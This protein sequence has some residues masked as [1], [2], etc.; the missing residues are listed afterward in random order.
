MAELNLTLR[1]VDRISSVDPA[2]W[3]ACAGSDNPFLLHGFLSA[4][5][6]SGS[7]NTRSGWQPAH[8]LVENPAK[9]L[10][11]AAPLYV[12]SHS[13]GEYVFDWGW[14]EA[15]QNA[16]RNY[17]PKLQ[18]AVPFTPAT[19]RRLLV[20]PDQDPL[21]LT[22]LLGDAMIGIADRNKLSS[23]HITFLTE[24][25]ARTLADH[26]WMLRIGEQY[27][28]HNQGYRTFEDFL[29]ALSSRKRKAIRKERERAN[30]HGLEI[31]CLS[32]AD[33]K[34]AH[35]DAFYRF[36]RDT[37]DRKWGQAYLTRD[38]FDRLTG[39]LAER[40]M[41]VMAEQDGHWVAG[42]L[43]FIGDDI[44]FG[45]NW[46]SIG[47]FRFL[48]FEMC[49]YRAIDFAIERGLQKVEAG[50][51]GEHKISRGYLPVPTYSV[52]W[53]REKPLRDAVAGFLERERIAMLR[54]IELQ[55]EEGPYRYEEPQAR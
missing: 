43:N 53:I 4:M 39:P 32:G 1:T 33:L 17:Y 13:Y 24:E 46:G 55:A 45:R 12:K 9:E 23:A 34:P 26:G 27:H 51:Q 21:A 18:S 40:I 38:F 8:L 52:H 29:A 48:H 37:S 19:G 54:Q 16:G 5:E 35:W 22:E 31:H 36:Y 25:E 14:A 20:R 28:W 50:A 42:A 44:L 7:A 15:W 49:Y 6:E 3:D 41:L 47:E 30:Q 11:A 10:L 2:A